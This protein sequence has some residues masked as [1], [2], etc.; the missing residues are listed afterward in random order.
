MEDA[1]ELEWPK[2][3]SQVKESLLLKNTAAKLLFPTSLGCIKYEKQLDSKFPYQK[4]KQLSKT[5][6]FVGRASFTKGLGFLEMISNILS[7]KGWRLKI[8]GTPSS[9]VS[10]NSNIDWLGWLN[11]RRLC[12]ECILN[13][14]TE[15][16]RGFWTRYR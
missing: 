9:T 7:K 2:R 3:L 16:N 13:S 4:V 10:V 8:T 14:C 15:L 11:T 1:K 5:V 6:L 12:E